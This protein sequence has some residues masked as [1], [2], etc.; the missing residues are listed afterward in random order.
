MKKILVIS[1]MAAFALASNAANKRMMEN[2]TIVADT[3]Y[4][5]ANRMNVADRSDA[6]Y[7]RLLLKA[8]KGQQKQDMFQDFYLNGSLKAEGGYSFIDLGNDNNTKMDGEVTTYYPNGKEKWRGQFANGKPN[9]YFTMQMR[10]GSIAVAE[11]VNGKSKFDY[12]T[13]TRP[14]GTIKRHSIN[15]LDSL[16]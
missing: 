16:L 8:G 10:D 5:D 7:Y 13:V 1:I 3:I 9:G 15:E 11:F 2:A 12:F 6:S 14:D 4:Y